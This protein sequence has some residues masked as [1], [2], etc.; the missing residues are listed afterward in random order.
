MGRSSALDGLS[1]AV[2][3]ESVCAWFKQAHTF[4]CCRYNIRVFLPSLTVTYL[5]RGFSSSAA[6]T[7]VVYGPPAPTDSL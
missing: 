1:R 3:A 4:V 7:L 5:L 2:I 6:T